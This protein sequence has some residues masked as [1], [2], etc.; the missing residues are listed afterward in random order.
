MATDRWGNKVSES[1]IASDESMNVYQKV[2][3]TRRHGLC[4]S[5]PT[6]WARAQEIVESRLHY[7]FAKVKTKQLI[8]LWGISIRCCWPSMI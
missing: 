6:T 8:T 3:S 5:A 7:V 4:G 2:R 1:R